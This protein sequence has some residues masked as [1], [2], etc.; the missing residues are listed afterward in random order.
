MIG[1]WKQAKAEVVATVKRVPWFGRDNTPDKHGRARPGKARADL[2]LS[3]AAAAAPVSNLA[4]GSAVDSADASTIKAAYAGIEYGLSEAMLG[5]FLRQGFIGHHTCALLASHWLIDRACHM[6][7]SDAVRRGYSIVSDDG[8][9]LPTDLVN[10]MRKFDERFQIVERMVDF[11]GRGRVFGIRIA[12]FVV[13]T[14]DPQ[15]YEQP[16]NPDGVRP[17]SYRGISLIDPYWCAPE[18]DRAAASD[19][20]SIHFHEPTWWNINGKRYHRS[21]LVIFRSGIV[22]DILRPLYRYGGVPIP[23]RIVERVYC[24]ERTANEAPQLAMTKR[25]TG[26]GTDISEFMANPTQSAERM[27]EWTDFRDNF[28]LKIYDKDAEELGQF[29]TSLADLD[30]V[31]MTQYQLVAGAAGVPVTK[32]LGTSPKGFNATGELDEANYHEELETIQSRDLRPLVERHHMLVMRSYIAP[33]LRDAKPVATSVVWEPLDTPTAKE[34]AETEKA[35]AERDAALADLGAIDGVDVRERLRKDVNGPYFGIDPASRGDEP[36]E[37]AATVAM[38]G[39]VTDAADGV[40]LVTNQRFLDPT[41]VAEKVTTRDFEVQVT[42]VFTDTDGGRFRIIVD[43][44]HSLAAARACGVA[45]TYVEG[46][47]MSGDYEV[48]ADA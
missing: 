37:P 15:Y 30:A 33:T 27:Q 23:Q 12:L 47:F 32:L 39:T 20:A 28:Q 44:H 41:I 43:G 2:V 22:P 10:R 18:L 8:S 48:V 5:F 35:E 7:A 25:T 46:D 17:E 13:E 3:Q 34:K 21:H 14:G 16:F 45:P 6:P 24:A 9:Q 42:P 38:P 4:P 11:V 29:D 36:A 19:P 26:F 1:W 40:R 31:I